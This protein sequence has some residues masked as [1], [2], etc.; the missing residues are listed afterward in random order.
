MITGLITGVIGWRVLV[1][2]GSSLP[3]GVAPIVL[4]VA[5]PLAWILGVNLGYVLGRWMAPFRQFGKFAAVGFTN[6]AVDTGI[7]NILIAWTGINSGG[8]FSV[9]KGVSFFGA[10]MH[11]YFWNKMWVFEAQTAGREAQT[12]GKFI[13]VALVSIVVN[14]GTAS[15]VVWA[16]PLFGLSGNAWANV[17]AIVGSAVALL[18]SF[19]GFRLLVFRK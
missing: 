19:V 8:F 15:A 3:L 17:A 1:F 2:L 11:S 18:F 10:V 9:F 4:V 5:V 14:V 6:F 13:S 12:F 7:L 16:G